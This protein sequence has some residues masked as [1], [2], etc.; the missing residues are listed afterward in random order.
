MKRELKAWLADNTVT[1]ENKGEK[2]LVLENAGN[3]TLGDILEKM[4]KQDTGLRMETLAH[5]VDLY[6]RTLMESVLTGY[7]I[8]TGLFRMVPQFKGVVEN[9]VWN[10][11]TNS[12]YV[13]LQQDKVLREGIAETSVKILGKKGSSAY[14]SGS[15][16][17]ATRATDGSATPGSPFRLKGKNIKVA[18][19]DEAVGVYLLSSN[20]DRTKLSMDKIVINYPSEVLVLLP[21]DLA[22][23][24]YELQIVTQFTAGN[25]LLRTPR[26]ISK[27]LFVGGGAQ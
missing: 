12:L 26:T 10:P 23:G 15:Q 27:M 25:W 20:G 22:G 14:I 9:G 21:A 18:G 16:D 5:A 1:G 7:S 8:N 3:L 2:I 11:A 6:H 24:D 17:I 13:L 19:T 4:K